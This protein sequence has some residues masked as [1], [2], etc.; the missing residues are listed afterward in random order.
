MTRASEVRHR[1]FVSAMIAVLVVASAIPTTGY[2]AQAAAPILEGCRVFLRQC[3]LVLLSAGA[4][5]RWIPIAALTA[6]VAYAIVDRL[7]LMRDLSRFLATN[8]T[9]R[10]V[11]EEALGRL[12]REFG[13]ESHLRV[14]V[15]HAG[16]PAFT[17]GLLRPRIYISAA[18]QQTLSAAELRAV[19]RHEL[20]HH[21]RRDPLR[22]AVLRFAAKTFFWLPLIGLLAEDLMEESEI[23]AD[24]FAASSVDGSDPLDVASAL[25]KLGRGHSF[26]ATPSIGGFT[27]IERRVHRLLDEPAHKKRAVPPRRSILVSIFALVIVWTTAT[28][29]PASTHGMTVAFGDPCAR[30]IAGMEGHCPK[31]ERRG[32]G[33]SDCPMAE[34]HTP[35]QTVT[36]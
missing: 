28:L 27:L 4:P 11:P 25:V 8:P 33:M 29:S 6:G 3:A 2:V 36:P 20:H 24:D 19:F 13:V 15:A 23:T 30:E 7:R 26:A 22:F 32:H 5:L 17:A 1:W 18:V 9:R 35:V 12:A 14:L 21:M 10:A 31:C 16:H 34:S